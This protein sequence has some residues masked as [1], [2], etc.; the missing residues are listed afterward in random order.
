MSW[1]PIRS[2]PLCCWLGLIAACGE[3]GAPATPPAGPV[4]SLSSPILIECPAATSQSATLSIGELGGTVDV[5]GSSISV[6]AAA[7]LVPTEITLTV[8]ASRYMEVEITANG[9]EEFQ[10]EQPV[11]V[12]IG[13]SRC[14]TDFGSTELTAWHIDSRTRALLEQMGGIDDKLTR[15]VTFS[16][17]HLS[18]YAIA[19]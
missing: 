2:A 10:F 9:L 19:E 12:A 13:Y 6:P 1:S 8:P 16:T 14:G 3:P 17:G 15:T 11:I 5:A 18:S 7:L 4:A